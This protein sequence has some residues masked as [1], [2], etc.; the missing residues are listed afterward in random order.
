MTAFSSESDSLRPVTPTSEMVIPCTKGWERNEGKYEMMHDTIELGL[1]INNTYYPIP[2]ALK[3]FID[4][5]WSISNQTP[6]FMHP[7]VGEGYYET[8]ANLS[9]SKDGSGI[10]LGG[11][12]IRLL[13][14]DGVLLEVTIANQPEP[15]KDE[16]YQKIEDGVVESITVFYDEVHTSIKLKDMELS[17]LTPE[18]LL[19]AYPGSEGWIHSPS[20]YSNHP[21]FGIS[22]DYYICRNLDNCQRTISIYFN[23][24]YTAFKITVLN[25]TPLKAYSK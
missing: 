6:Y 7:M 5:G 17:S 11:S 10:C 14:K 19:A 9:L 24:E 22:I 13:E 8:R 25:Q 21:E 12:I 3:Q 15:E 1:T 16:K 18:A 20:N 2:R 23:L 4:D